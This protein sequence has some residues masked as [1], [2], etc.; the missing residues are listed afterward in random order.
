VKIVRV[1]TAEYEVHNNKAYGSVTEN[2]VVVIQAEP[3][4]RLGRLQA[5]DSLAP[6]IPRGRGCARYDGGLGVIYCH[7][8]GWWYSFAAKADVGGRWLR[9]II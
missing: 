8:A 7:R 4:I 3:M 6:S 5:A 9:T 1:A 2:A